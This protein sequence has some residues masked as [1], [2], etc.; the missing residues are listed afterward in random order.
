MTAAKAGRAGESDPA[1]V[2]VGMGGNVGA[3][4]GTFLTALDRLDEQGVQVEAVS[5]LYGSRPLGPEQP[6]FINAALRCRWAPPLDELLCLLQGL[7]HALGR[8]RT[9]RWGPRTLDLDILYAEGRWAAS[10]TLTVP[11][12]ALG[13]REFALR[14]LLDVV[15][16]A[17]DPRTGRPYRDVLIELGS[18]GVWEFSDPAWP[19]ALPA[20][21]VAR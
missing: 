15:P 21:G 12:V 14:P 3:V 19:K 6:D 4:V 16:D 10:P 1:V 2:V 17:R 11:H 5:R 8:V 9:I 20:G 13:E 7:E 18:Q